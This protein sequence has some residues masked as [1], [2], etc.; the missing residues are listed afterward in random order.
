MGARAGVVVGV[1]VALASACASPALA[2]KRV[3][4]RPDL[5]VSAGSAGLSAT[6]GKVTGKF[7]VANSGTKASKKSTAA[8]IVGTGAARR[9]AKRFV[10]P[11][12]KPRKSKS[13]TVTVTLPKKLPSGVLRLRVCADANHRQRERSEANNCRWVGTTAKRSV[14]PA[15]APVAP[16]SPVWTAP[17]PLAYTP[18]QGLHVAYSGGDYW[19]EV[20]ASYDTTPIPALVWLHGCGGSSASDIYHVP[21]AGSRHYISILPG[22]NEGGCWGPEDVPRVLSALRDAEQHFDID[23]HRVL[24]GGFS[25]GGDV[26]YITA[27]QNAGLFAGV[28]GVNCQ[29]LQGDG[30]AEIAEAAWRFHIVQLAHTEDEAYDINDIR[31]QTDQLAAAGFPTQRI[32]LPGTHFV[33]DTNGVGGTINDY[34]QYLL[35]HIDDGWTSP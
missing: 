24:I 25:S 23:P 1:A 12:L 30:T 33:S 6:S 4:A 35:P 32:E 13:F 29:P 26:A 17:Q 20:P 15:A 9:T 7:T 19:T 27:F 16:V 28:L 2:A 10:V 11:A 8:L 14:P 3:P 5:R 18:G 22:G 21:T 34:L 31:R